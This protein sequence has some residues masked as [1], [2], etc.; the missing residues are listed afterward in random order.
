MCSKCSI[1][2]LWVFSEC[3]LSV[4]L[5]ISG[6]ALGK[7][8]YPATTSGQFQLRVTLDSIPLVRF[9]NH[10]FWSVLG[11]LWVFSEYA[12]SVPW[13]FSECSLSVLWVFSECS[14]SVLLV[15][16]LAKDRFRWLLSHGAKILWYFCGDSTALGAIEVLVKEDFKDVVEH[17]RIGPI[18]II[19]QPKFD[20]KFN[21]W[22]SGP[23]IPH[24]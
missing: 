2:A 9:P 12:L 20:T 1:S 18:S 22:R 13:V 17:L 11:V 7:S 3:A 5:V 4:L 6:C 10:Y 15:L 24:I 14:L 19:P 23:C 16:S 21:P 8:G